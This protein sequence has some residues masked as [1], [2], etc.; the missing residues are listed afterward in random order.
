MDMKVDRFFEIGGK[1]FVLLFR[2]DEVKRALLE[3]EGITAFELDLE[4]L[5]SR[6]LIARLLQ[7]LGEEAVYREHRFPATAGGAKDRLLLTVSGFFLPDRSTLL[8]DRE[9]PGDLLQFFADKGIRVVY[10][11]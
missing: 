4:S 7:A 2:A 5:S 8:T 9:I 10:F 6:E 3:R 1:K 11:R